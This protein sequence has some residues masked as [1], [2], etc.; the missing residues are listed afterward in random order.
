ME[1]INVKRIVT[2]ILFLI[3]LI[4]IIPVSKVLAVTPKDYTVTDTISAKLDSNGVLTLTG[5][6]EMPDYSNANLVPWK[7]EQIQKIIINDGITKIGK[8]AFNS[9][10]SLKD[11]DYGNTLVT[12]GEKGFYGCTSLTEFIAPSSLEN[13]EYAAFAYCENITNIELNEGL[14]LLDSYCFEGTS[15]KTVTI[16]STLEDYNSYVFQNVLTLEEFKVAEGN[17]TFWTD[18]GVLCETP[19]DTIDVNLLAYPPASKLKTYKV[20][21]N[22]TALRSDCFANAV[23]LEEIILP[24]TLI[25]INSDAFRNCGIKSITLKG[26][27]LEVFGIELFRDCK[28][29]E[30]A[31]IE[32]NIPEGYMGTGL[33][34]TFM[35]CT[36][37]KNVNITSDVETIG[38]ETFA[39]CM[40]LEKIVL[41][42]SVK[43]IEEEAFSGCANLKEINIPTGVE[44]IEKETFINCTSLEKIVLPES[45]KYI[46]TEAFSGCTNLKEVVMP[47]TIVGIHKTA[48]EG[49]NLLDT[50]YPD[51]FVLND[52]G[53]YMEADKPFKI[54]GDFKYD[55]TKE[56][57]DIVNK[58]RAKV[59]VEPLKMD[60]KLFETAQQRVAEIAVLYSHTRPNLT[61]CFSIFPSEGQN[62]GENIAAGMYANE[63][64]EQV[65]ES[66]MES[67]GHKGNILDENFKY[68]GIG[69]FYHDMKYYWVQCFSDEGTE[70]TNYPQNETKQMQ[71]PVK[72]ELINYSTYDNN[73]IKLTTNEKVDIEIF[74]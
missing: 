36:N 74:R 30:T 61:D 44:T 51:G 8:Y 58:E 40:S 3:L 14:K 43:Y 64:P 15:V 45:V 9:L 70:M 47:D 33:S 65:M 50:K 27:D 13:I 22:I 54:S 1:K 38:K 66:W 2:I 31:N 48:F 60:T 42:D 55:F 52:D 19:G 67:P 16:P 37:L 49:C 57:L 62:K 6:G 63:T 28:K 29:L 32:I 5:T 56:V 71:V 20:P 68:I 7:G 4:S 53:Y 59:G 18:N 10:T 11:V 46:E 24:D 72:N 26:S 35:N 69:C 41:P 23:N 34:Y 21:E 25:V 73:L 17:P 39:N 12:I